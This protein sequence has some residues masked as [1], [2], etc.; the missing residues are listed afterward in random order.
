MGILKSPWSTPLLANFK[1]FFTSESAWRSVRNTV[2]LNSAFIFFGTSFS[3]I[4]ALVFNEINAKLFKKI[5]Q[6]FMMLP[7][8]VSWI[9]V[10]AFAYSFFNYNTGIM[11]SFLQSL[12]L[13]KVD[14]YLWKEA[15]PFILLLISLWKGTGYGMV[16]YSA[17]LS[18]IDTSYY[19]AA[20][21]D[22][23]SKLQQIRYIS[24]PLLMPTA[25][26]LT[27]LAVGRILNSD[28]GMFYAL[29]GENAQL[30]PTTDVIDTFAYRTLRKI[31][32]MGM[33]SATTFVQSVIGFL[34]VLISN[35]AV[36]KCNPD[37]AIF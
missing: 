29:I 9:I 35:L 13:G 14:W 23:A 33:S 19:E 7:Y 31:G 6:S 17:V 10:G 27:L 30:Y 26:L 24:V 22:G 11:N 4:A 21:I 36:K 2:L 3:V 12:G 16:I 20:E 8:F 34:L 32:D 5:T 15:W 1:F 37:G 25:M 28:F 18:G